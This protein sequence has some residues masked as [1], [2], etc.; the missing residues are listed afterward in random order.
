MILIKDQEYET[1]IKAAKKEIDKLR[2][3]LA[4]T[5]PVRERLD[6]IQYELHLWYNRIGI[7][8]LNAW[9]DEQK[10]R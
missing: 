9:E 4:E 10:T 5:L 6:E 3:E 7:L 1:E 2:K 8:F